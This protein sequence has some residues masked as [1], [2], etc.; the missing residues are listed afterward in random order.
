MPTD[1]YNVL[2]TVDDHR[3]SKGARPSPGWNPDD[4]LRGTDPPGTMAA[5]TDIE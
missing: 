4:A 1:Y 2:L 3:H 5:I